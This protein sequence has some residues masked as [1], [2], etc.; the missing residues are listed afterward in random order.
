MAFV[1]TDLVNGFESDV[2]PIN[3]L[4]QAVAA[5]DAIL[6]Q[7]SGWTAA[8][9][10]GTWVPRGI[11]YPPVSYRKLAQPTNS[12]QIAG[13]A[14][15]GTIPNSTI[16]TLPSGFRPINEQVVNNSSGVIGISTAGVVSAIAF[17]SSFVQCAFIIPLDL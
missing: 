7:A 1:W 9:L 15:G 17:T 6:S 3:L 10:A 8:T 2:D 13:Q 12:L 11:G 5:H 14:Q 16:F 4:G